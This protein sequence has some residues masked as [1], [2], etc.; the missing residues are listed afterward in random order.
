MIYGAH[1]HTPE[2]ARARRTHR[3][4][5]CYNFI[6]STKRH[7]VISNP[8]QHFFGRHAIHGP[9]AIPFETGIHT[10]IDTSNN[11]ILFRKKG[12]LQ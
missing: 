12:Q 6:Q 9:N 10:T 11:I 1:A 7:C 3:E 5:I 2:G 4:N 8:M